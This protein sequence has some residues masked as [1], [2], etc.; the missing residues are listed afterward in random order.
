MKNFNP[1]D[2]LLFEA[3]AG[4]QL[5][6]TD[7]PE[8]D[9]DTRGVCLPPLWVLVDP[10]ENFNVKDSFDGED[11]VIYDLGKFMSLSKDMNPN[12]V[13]LLFVPDN[14][15]V[16]TSPTWEHIVENK[17]LF[18]SKKAKYTFTGYAFSQLK[19]L[20]RHRQWFL[21]PPDHKPTRMEY[22]LTQT[23]LVSE[24]N[25][26]NV[27]S[28]PHELFKDEHHDEL[29]NERAYRDAKKLWDGYD[30][31]K[32]NRNPKRKGTEEMY[33]YDTK[34]ASHVF[35]LMQEGKELLLTGNITF[36]LVNAE[37]LLDVKSGCLP[38]E[39]M[40]D[41]AV[42]MEADFETWYKQSPLPKSPDVNGLKKL[43]MEVLDMER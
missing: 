3:V 19:A 36:P 30:Q 7:T 35:R 28:V 20:E 17:H 42:E 40:M 12:V 5:Y 24:A 34:Y 18:L 6:G 26:Q 10:F 31:W 11:K 15:K 13:E 37:W 39:E 38:Y 8:S 27:L 2:Y 9:L 32:K 14:K 25:L 22:G 16:F 1:L 41:M 21:N 23:A 33:G 43:Y 29:V 4:S